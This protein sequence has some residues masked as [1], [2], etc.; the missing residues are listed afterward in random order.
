[1]LADPGKGRVFAAG[2]VAARVED[3]ERLL[4]DM[5][6]QQAHPGMAAAADDFDGSCGFEHRVVLRDALM[7]GRLRRR[8]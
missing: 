7:A 4:R 5:G 1:L 6:V 8:G 2:G 3:R